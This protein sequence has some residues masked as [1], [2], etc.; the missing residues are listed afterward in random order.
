[1]NGDYPRDALKPGHLLLWYKIETVLGEGGF[2]ITYLAHDVNLD[3]KVAIKEYL[4]SDMC[5]RQDDHTIA[6]NTNSLEDFETGLNRFIREAR[7]LAKFEHPNVVKVSNVFEENSTAYMAMAYE[8]GKD[9]KT[10]LSPRKT[11][12]EDHI[13]SIILPILDGLEYVHDSG[14]IHRDIKPGNIMI[15]EDGSPVLIDFGSVHDTK[16]AKE[17]VTTLVSPGF[18]PH[19]QYVGKP[20]LQGP[21]T[22]IY[23]L[24]ATLY[25]C[26]YGTNPI[27]AITRGSALIKQEADPLQPAAKIKSEKY[28]PCLLEAIDRALAFNEKDRP[29]D[30]LE[31]R[32]ELVG[33]CEEKLN[34]TL[35]EGNKLIS[36]ITRSHKTTRTVKP[37][38]TV[39]LKTTTTPKTDNK[40]PF[41]K[42]ASIT[43]VAITGIL[44]FSF[45]GEDKVKEIVKKPPTIN[46]S[47]LNIASVT[48][49]SVPTP[50]STEG[51]EEGLLPVTNILKGEITDKLS[52]GS[53]APTLVIIPKGSN[54][55]GSD[56]EEE[57]HR[58]DEQPKRL[59]TIKKSIA[60]GK[61][62][63]TVAEFKKF[64]DATGYVTSAEA[65]ASRGCRTNQQGS[66]D[67]T[68]GTSWANPGYAQEAN[69]PVVCVSWMDAMAY[70]KWLSH[71]T[72]EEY[73][74]PSELTWEYASRAGTT[75]SRFWGDE[76]AC[77]YSNVSDFSRAAMH[78]LDISSKNIFPCEDGNAYSA[79]VATYKPNQF[80]L[81]DT[82]GNVWEWTND[83]WNPDH[84][85]INEDGTARLEGNCNN[86]V[87]RGGSWGNLPT[88][89]RAAKRLTDPEYY[90]YYNLGFRVSRN[91]DS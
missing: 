31:W 29:Q 36:S 28:S 23:S 63:V 68:V 38:T 13:L 52:D 85:N 18:T 9:L 82:I 30:V 49:G 16:K 11:I 45:S 44:M 60:I 81:Y 73:Q 91:I 86:H 48:T 27:D 50:T 67:W 76:R 43:A 22:D 53:S 71:E 15:R 89:V 5:Q 14:F 74:L 1:M 65:D 69:H 56:D 54:V 62:E 57:G 25:R 66:W 70:I 72:G 8:K 77:E 26:V 78:G 46:S 64:I 33:E 2:G 7:T 58:K 6:P 80:G 83:C 55:I 84:S 37:D 40:L 32:E 24:G 3:K 35:N 21:W 59:I 47:P 39:D 12:D 51:K 19:E 88:L 79:K 17:N 61:T 4:P 90:R 20:E 34:D 10:M 87:Y 41:L 42:V 75:T